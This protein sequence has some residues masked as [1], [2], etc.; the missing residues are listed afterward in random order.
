MLAIKNNNLD[1]VIILCRRGA[2]VNQGNKKDGFT[3]LRMAVDKHNEPIVK[4]LLNNTS[5]NGLQKD[6]NNRSPFD[7]AKRLQDSNREARQVYAL[8]EEYMVGIYFGM[9]SKVC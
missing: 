8:I 1:C 4:Y 6:Y 9:S 7:V 5:A 2:N 3:P